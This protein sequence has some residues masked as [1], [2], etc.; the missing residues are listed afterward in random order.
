MAEAAHEL[1]V[2]LDE[3]GVGTTT[4]TVGATHR[5]LTP[6]GAFVS[7]RPRPLGREHT[8]RATVMAV[9]D[10]DDDLDVNDEGP[11]L[12]SGV[13]PRTVLGNETTA[14]LQV[15]A[16]DLKNVHIVLVQVQN[17]ASGTR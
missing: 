8:R 11:P 4:M 14:C 3:R 7:G 17:L 16:K 15:L 6:Q 13:D 12:P 1:G 2:D 10:D 5:S 9:S